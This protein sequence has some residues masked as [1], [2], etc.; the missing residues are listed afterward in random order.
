MLAVS[1]T[2][3]DIERALAVKLAY[4]TRPDGSTFYKPDRAPSL[5]LDVKVA[6]VAGID[7]AFV[8]RHRGGSQLNGTAYG[9]PDLRNAYA[10]MCLGLTGA[11]ETVGLME[12]GGYLHP[13]IADYKNQR[14]GSP[15][16]APAAPRCRARPR[17]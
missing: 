15:A 1:G 13:D 6:H 11:G 7:T 17:A 4:A 16:R 12:Y 10:G 8:P 5:D 2:A 3:A 14:W 9:S